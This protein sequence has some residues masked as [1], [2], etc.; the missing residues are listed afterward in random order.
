MSKKKSVDHG[1]LTSYII[2]AIV[3]AIALGYFAP[4]IAVKFEVGGKV[5]AC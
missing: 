4:E 2:G 5:L 1:N 3:A